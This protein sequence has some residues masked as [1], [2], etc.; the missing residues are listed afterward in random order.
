MNST[1]FNTH[2]MGRAG[3]GKTFFVSNQA[4]AL[5][6]E[7]K[8]VF[9]IDW[10]NVDTFPEAPSL[11][12]KPPA[13]SVFILTNNPNDDAFGYENLENMVKEFLQKN[14]SAKVIIAKDQIGEARATRICNLLLDV[15]L[16]NKEL[17][18]DYFIFIDET[19]MFDSKKI[20]QLLS[21]SKDLHISLTI[22][23]QYMGQV[24]EELGDTLLR[25][26]KNIIFNI[27]PFESKHVA[28]IYNVDPALLENLKPYE[29]KEFEP[30]N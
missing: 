6:K 27:S 17:F 4:S 26:C 23:H 24:S 2:I 5:F 1:N 13:N 29:Y 3:S 28:S 7:G 12:I 20:Q 10:Y 15:I 19:Y 18:A 25:T 11:V 14:S 22:V 8:K 30:I 21:D 9:Y 16:N